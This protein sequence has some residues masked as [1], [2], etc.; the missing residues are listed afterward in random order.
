MVYGMLR[1]LQIIG[2]PILK[3]EAFTFKT[4]LHLINRVLCRSIAHL[5]LTSCLGPG[6]RLTATILL[7]YLRIICTKWTV[8]LQLFERAHFV[9]YPLLLFY[10]YH[11]WRL[12]IKNEIN[13]HRIVWSKSCQIRKLVT[14]ENVPCRLG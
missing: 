2:I 10:M 3:Q 6:P 13:F 7:E 1:R 4:V 5:S 8:F 12:I 11:I 9:T 14:C